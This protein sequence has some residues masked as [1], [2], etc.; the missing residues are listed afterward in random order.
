[1][2][3]EDSQGVCSPCV[4]TFCRQAL[5][6]PAQTYLCGLLSDVERKNIASIASRCGQDRLPL[7]RFIGWAPWEDVP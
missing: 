6:Q 3:E 1:M 7:Q 2:S 5:D 4:E